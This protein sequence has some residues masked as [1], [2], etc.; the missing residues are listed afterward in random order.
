MRDYID[1]GSAPYDEHCVQVQPGVDYL[2]AMREE[3]KRFIKRIREVHGDEPD[4]AELAIKSNPHDFGTYLAVVCYYWEDDEEAL[5][6][7]IKCQDEMP[8]RWED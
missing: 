1:I 3:C 4:S 6:Y 7:A 2:P 5:A 8:S